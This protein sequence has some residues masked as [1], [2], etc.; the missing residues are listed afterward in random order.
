MPVMVT[1]PKKVPPL[2]Q[3]AVVLQVASPG[4]PVFATGGL[5]GLSIELV[6]KNQ[7]TNKSVRTGKTLKFTM[8]IKLSR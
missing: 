5:L 7:E 1:E 2:W 4:A 8:F 3:P 6:S